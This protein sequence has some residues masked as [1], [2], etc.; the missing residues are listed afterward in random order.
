[1]KHNDDIDDPCVAELDVVVC[2]DLAESGS[3]QQE[4]QAVYLLQ[5]PLRPPWRPY[6]GAGKAPTARMKPNARRMEIDVPLATHTVNY[7][8]A[9]EEHKRIKAVTLRSAPVENRT[10]FAVGRIQDGTLYLVPIDHCLQLRPTCSH[11]H[12]VEPAKKAAAS[13]GGSGAAAAGKEETE[14]EEE[15]AGTDDLGAGGVD[16]PKV[17]AVEVKVTKRETERQQQARLNSYAYIAQKEE[18]EPWAELSL[19]DGESAQSQALWDSLLSNKGVAVEVDMDRA[20]YLRSIAPIGDSYGGDGAGA[21]GRGGAGG[22]STSG[23]GGH[24][25]MDAAAQAA[26]AS[27]LKALFIRHSVC[28]MAN[29]RQWLGDA[30]EAAGSPR[31]A[32][33]FSDRALHEAILAAGDYVCIRRLYVLRVTGQAGLDPLRCVV[34]DALRDRERLKKGELLEAAEAAGVK[35]TDTMYNKVVKDICN[36]HGN[37]WLLKPG[38]D[39]PLLP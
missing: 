26:L 19:H 35:V 38:V 13:R 23:A 25:G 7:S 30:P 39:G 5:Y 4:R 32:A 21:D 2:N 9:V 20:E 17:T 10:S 28:T 36:S 12:V 37:H 6:E 15:E 14:E 16:E 11:L 1:M 27:A 24:L 29:V 33:Y 18:E 31:S 34:V 22:A 8:D 3:P